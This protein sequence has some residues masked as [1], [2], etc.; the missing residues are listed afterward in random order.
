MMC[1]T[2]EQRQALAQRAREELARRHYVDWV[3]L[4]HRGQ[5]KPFAVHR[6]ICDKLEAVMRGEC[7]RLIISMPPRHGKSNTISETLPSYFLAKHP[8]KKV[9]VTSKDEELATRFGMLNRRKVEEFGAV[10]GVSVL[11]GASSKTNWMTSNGGQA[12]FAPI[13]GGITGS[14]ADLMIIDDPVKN[15]EQA[16]SE[17]QRNKLWEEWTAT[18]RTRIEGSGAVIVIMTRW[19]EDDLAGRLIKG[20]G[21]EV[22]SIPCQAEDNDPLGRKPGEMLCPELGYNEEWAERTKKEVGGRV[23]EALYQQHPTQQQGGIFKR[24]WVKRYSSLPSKLNDEGERVIDVDEWCQSWD[25]TFKGEKNSDYVAGG[26]WARRGSEHYLVAIIHERLDFT[27][28]IAKIKAISA[29]Y[30]QAVRKLIEDKANGSAVMSM[31]RTQLPGIIPVLPTKSKEA[32]AN[33]VTPFFEAG[34]IYVPEGFAGD[35]YIN[36]LCAFPNGKHDD[37]VDQTS[38]YL[39]RHIRKPTARVAVL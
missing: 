11:R 9:I 22:L 23:W 25:L 8:N 26:V 5:W 24:E 39:S 21:W 4:T 37:Q 1:L 36:E 3:E 7:P 30:P 28:T 19:H 35:M 18:L 15:E 16:Q 27:Q 31:L 33:A 17:L 6:L 34:N 12:L 2:E 29:A 38:Q 13:M 32:R 20:G 14:G 10:F